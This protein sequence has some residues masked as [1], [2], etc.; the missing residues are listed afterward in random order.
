MFAILIKLDSPGPVFHRGLRVGK[1]GKV[2]R[3]YKFRSMVANAEKI[4]GPSTPDDD[5]RITKIGRFLR[6]YKIDELPQLINVLKGEMSFVGPRPEVPEEV[7]TYTEEEKALLTVLPGMTDWA[8]L[9][10]IDEGAILKESKDPHQ[11]YREK[12]KPEKI[13]L[14]LE[15]VKNHSFWIDLKIIFKT[16][17]AVLFRK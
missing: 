14:A 13:R 4:G 9:A 1:H 3:I 2:F 15:Y 6:K 11:T 17:K 16:I 8:S 5:L 7:E 10:D 12:I